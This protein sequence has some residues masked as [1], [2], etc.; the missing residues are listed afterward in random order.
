[1][2]NEAQNLYDQLLLTS[3]SLNLIDAR[4]VEINESLATNNPQRKEKK[5]K[6]VVFSITPIGGTIA[7]LLSSPT[8]IETF[9]KNAIIVT[10]CFYLGEACSTLKEA[11][12]QKVVAP[13]AENEEETQS[14]IQEKEM[15]VK[16][17]GILEKRL[18]S[19]V[20][21]YKNLTYEKENQKIK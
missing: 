19:Q 9:L 21:A 20:K 12:M 5:N 15:L 18:T 17:R 4:I 1:M 8:N 14:L 13:P 10:G 7:S 16:K 6:L 11:L 2:E 3:H